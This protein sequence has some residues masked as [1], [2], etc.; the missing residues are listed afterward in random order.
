LQFGFGHRN[1]FLSSI[2]EAGRE[3]VELAREVVVVVVGVVGEGTREVAGVFAGVGV[4][5]Y[6]RAGGTPPAYGLAGSTG[7]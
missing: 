1:G 6:K 7:E 3:Q 4:E 2:L 5:E